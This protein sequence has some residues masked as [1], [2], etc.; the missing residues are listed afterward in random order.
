MNTY[1]TI[2]NRI[3]ESLERGVV[4][5]RKQWKAR[6][7][8]SPF[9]HNFATG[10]TYRGINFFSL[11]CS[12]YSSAEWMT[13]K[14]AEAMG[15]QVRKGEHGSPVV[16]WKFERGKVVKNPR[17]G[18]ERESGPMLRQ[19]TVFNV[20]QIDGLQPEL[21]LD[22]PAFDPVASAQAIA[23]AYMASDS[24]P[25]LAHGG[26]SAFYLPTRDHVQVPHP[27]AFTSPAAYYATLFHEFAHS[28]GHVKRLDRK[29][30]GGFGSRDYSDEELVAEFTASF[31][32]AE[33]RVSNDQLLDN[34]AAY[35][36][37][38][39][40]KFKGD[41]RVAVHAAQRAQKAA[42]YILGRWAAAQVEE[43]AEV[44]AEVAA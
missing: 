34:S 3:I 19:Y 41:A 13:Y 39:L 24:H 43:S 25:S 17:T 5:W 9:P 2:T 38:W 26:D 18:E 14:Q 12:P 40:E 42:D 37:G 8:G 44:A 29:L 33:A 23:D 10:K 16:F 31:L 30:A 35:I 21:P 22:A 7:S 27:G 20:E 11:L 36:G 15:A 28:T 32:S 6:A 4:P 1:E